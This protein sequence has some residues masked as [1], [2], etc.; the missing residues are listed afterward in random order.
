[1]RVVHIQA[2]RGGQAVGDDERQVFQALQLAGMLVANLQPHGVVSLF[3]LQR[4]L[5]SDRGSRE[6]C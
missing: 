2:E 6:G 4:V 3:Q 5:Q 1:M